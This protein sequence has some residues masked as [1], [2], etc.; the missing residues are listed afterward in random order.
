MIAPCF[1]SKLAPYMSALLAERV[2]SG[3]FTG[4]L[5]VC[6]K[7]FDTFIIEK[8]FDDGTLPQALVDAWSIQRPTEKR[9][10]LPGKSVRYSSHSSINGNLYQGFLNT[11][12]VLIPC[13][14]GCT[15]ASVCA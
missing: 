14:S 8:G 6:L 9:M 7:N 3:F 10:C 11:Y 12:P 4:T 15:T 13:C 5:I 2:D 1:N